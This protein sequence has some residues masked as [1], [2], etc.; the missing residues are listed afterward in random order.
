MD[1]KNEYWEYFIANKSLWVKRT[2]IYKLNRFKER[3]FSNKAL[4]DDLLFR[5]GGNNKT[6][7]EMKATDEPCY[8][9]AFSNFAIEIYY[10]INGLK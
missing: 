1:K 6:P 5:H 10:I 2:T 4:W 3:L 9:H 7:K 8:N